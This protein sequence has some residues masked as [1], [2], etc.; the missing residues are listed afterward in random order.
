M[1]KNKSYF[2]S[3]KYCDSF[4]WSRICLN[5]LFSSGTNI[6]FPS[7][8]IFNKKYFFNLSDL[9]NCS[10]VTKPKSIATC[11]GSKNESALKNII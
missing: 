1:I 9:T 3:A 6:V 7:W 5:F 2:L 8:S 4:W 10:N 11:I